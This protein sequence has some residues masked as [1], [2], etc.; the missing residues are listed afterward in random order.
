MKAKKKIFEVK[1]QK[2]QNYNPKKL[3]LCME[4]E[5]KIEPLKYFKIILLI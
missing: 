1:K 2:K 4:A 5:E 3:I